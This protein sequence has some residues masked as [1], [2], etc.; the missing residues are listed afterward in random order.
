LKQ[1]DKRALTLLLLFVACYVIYIYLVEPAIFREEAQHAPPPAASRDIVWLQQN[2]QA[3]D[4]MLA[5]ARKHM[6]EIKNRAIGGT[7]EAVLKSNTQT[8]LSGMITEA[9]LAVK[10][11][12]VK[13]SEVITQ[14][15]ILLPVQLVLEGAYADLLKFL[16]N[17]Q[18]AGYLHT[19]ESLRIHK[20][21]DDFTIHLEIRLLGFLHD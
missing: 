21:G 17:L 19:V 7:S 10:T 4:T 18:Q 6:G 13:D 3:I 5:K 11:T 16:R 12:T 14:D 1:R 20:T 9:G 15:I 8:L 2:Q